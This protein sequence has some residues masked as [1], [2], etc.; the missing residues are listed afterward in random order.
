MTAPSSPRPEEI[1]PTPPPAPAT[2]D[3]PSEEDVEDDED[4]SDEDE[5]EESDE[6]S[7]DDDEDQEAEARGE[8][9]TVR[10]ATAVAQR[11]RHYI[12]QGIDLD[13]ETVTSEKDG[14]IA[15]LVV[16][17]RLAWADPG[18]SDDLARMMIEAIADGYGVPVGEIEHGVEADVLGLLAD[19]EQAHPRPQVPRRASA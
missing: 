15:G 9:A 5:D 1:D 14:Y 11:A 8:A 13:Q 12:D 7:E 18:L 3:E 6:D 16:G 4:E 19:Y 17:I 2:T 10:T